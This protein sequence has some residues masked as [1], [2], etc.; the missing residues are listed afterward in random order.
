M[1]D[2]AAAAAIVAS[3][4]NIS[5]K[6]RALAGDG[7]SRSEIADLVDRSYQQVRQVLVEDERRAGRR[8][9]RPGLAPPQVDAPPVE[10]VAE[11]ALPFGATWRLKLGS[12]GVVQLPAA[13]QAALGVRAGGV[14]I[15]ELEGDSFRIL[16]PRAAWER[17]RRRLDLPAR[18]ERDLVAELIAE[19]RAEAA[20]EDGDD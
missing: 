8:A 19:R 14:L 13:V 3:G 12:D 18:S 2:P 9:A 10:G 5:D 15:C 20:R 17:V 6:I 1:R 16:G 7:W 4:R 11:E